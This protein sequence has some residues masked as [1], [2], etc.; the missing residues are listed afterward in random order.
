[1]Q[2]IDEIV[3]SVTAS[4][5]RTLVQLQKID[6]SKGDLA[7][8]WAMKTGAA[9][10]Q[11]LDFNKPLNLIEQLNQTFT[12][13]ATA[14]AAKILLL[15]HSRS[16]PLTLNLGPVRG[17]DIESDYDGGLAAEVFAAVNPENNDKLKSDIRKVSNMQARFKYVFFMC[18]GYKESRLENLEAESGV[19]VWS[20]GAEL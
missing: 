3:R 10:C 1:M 14:R 7:A 11:P 15:R 8:L 20:V 9:G 17:S 18:P 12:Y 6:R 4:A 16:V 5:Q 2:D 13:I 19:Q